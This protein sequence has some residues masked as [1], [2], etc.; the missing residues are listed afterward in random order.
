M[1]FG[2]VVDESLLRYHLMAAGNRIDGMNEPMNDSLI[3]LVAKSG[4]D[5]HFQTGTDR[6]PAGV[7]WEPRPRPGPLR[8]HR[9]AGPL[10]SVQR[11]RIGLPPRRHYT[12]RQP[13]WS[14]LVTISPIAL[15]VSSSFFFF[16]NQECWTFNVI[17]WQARKEGDRQMRAGLIPSRMLQEKRIAYE[18][19][20]FA[21]NNG[22]SLVGKSHSHIHPI[23]QPDSMLMTCCSSR[24]LVKPSPPSPP[25]ADHFNQP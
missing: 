22:H 23:H 13:G 25:V 11:G 3:W 4:R 9:S 16:L 15:K 24:W 18:R 10:H 21:N 7:P 19:A 2:W 20:H 14:I 6:E 8:L 17:R 5:H 1:K 12:Y